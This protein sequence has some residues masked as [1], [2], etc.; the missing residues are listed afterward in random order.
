[1]AGD[2]ALGLILLPCFCFLCCLEMS[3]NNQAANAPPNHSANNCRS[4][5]CLL[6]TLLILSLI[7][8]LFGILGMMQF[9]STTSEFKTINKK[10]IV[11]YLKGIEI[12]IGGI[13][14]VFPIIFFG[15]SIAF[16][17]FTCGRREYQVLSVKKYMILNTLKIVCIVISSIF[18]ALSLLYSVL[19]TI[20]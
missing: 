16:L 18:I 1:M 11:K 8:S 4:R 2:D 12:G 17:V 6:V 7:Y 5:I 15:M 3:K 9:F 19:I 20:A 14:Y 10:G 13:L